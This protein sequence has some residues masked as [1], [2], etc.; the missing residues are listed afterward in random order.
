MQ[1]A[2]LRVCALPSDAPSRLVVEPLVR[3]ALLEDLANGHD[4]TTEAIVGADRT[5]RASIAARAGGVV[6]GIDVA[7]LAF[8][9]VDDRISVKPH[10]RD[11]EYVESGTSIATVEGP[12]RGMLTA[13]RPALNFLGRLSGIATATHRL[14]EL[15]AGTRARIADT[16]KTTPGLRVLEKYAVRCGGGANHRFGL[17]EAVLVKDNHIAVA[18]SIRAA[19]AA[20]RERVGHMVKVEVEV[21]TLEQLREVLEC[22]VDVVLCDNMAPAQLAQAVELVAGRALVEASGGVREETVAAIARTG[23]DLITSGSITN[24][25]PALDIALDFE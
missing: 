14:V 11:G 15:A 17:G 7:A 16:R 1:N 24:G 21:D 12:A 18:G 2:P 25:A 4:L 22:G 23:V 6:A 13:E 5:A 3:A 9:L 20:V 8:A 19:I 10:A